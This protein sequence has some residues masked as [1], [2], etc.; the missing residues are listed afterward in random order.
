MKR[1]F[2]I[3]LAI[4]I[5]A[6]VFPVY[7]YSPA[8]V[9]ASELVPTNMSLIISDSF[10]VDGVNRITGSELN[11]T[12]TEVG[13]KTWEASSAF[14][15]AGSGNE[16]YVTSAYS[17]TRTAFVPYVPAASLASIEMDMKPFGMGGW[18]A[19][20]FGK[21]ASAFWGGGQ[22]WMFLREDGYY[23]IWVNGTQNLLAAGSIPSFDP[24]VYT[25]LRLDYNADMQ[26]V[27]VWVNDDSIVNASNIG[28]I[29]GFTPDIQ[30]AGFMASE[31]TPNEAAFKNFQ[32]K[33]EAPPVENPLPLTISDSFTLD[34]VN[35]IA[36]EALSGT[37]TEVGDR[38]W[39]AN[40]EFIFAGSGSGG[41]VTSTS[42]GTKTAF[43]PYVPAGTMSS[44]EVD[45]KPFGMG[46]WSAVGFSKEASAF[47]GSGQIWMFLRED[48][49]YNIWVNGTQNLL[50]NGFIA[51]FDPD[52]YTHLRLE[53]DAVMQTV[54]VWVNEDSIVNASNIGAIQGF[55]PD[56][57]YAGFMVSAQTP[58]ETA[59]KNFQVKGPA[60]PIED[61]LPLT[62]SDSFAVD[63]VNRTAGSEL[64][65]TKTEVGERTWE[66]SYAFVFAGSGNEGYVT[67]AYS[68]TRT[69][70]VP[71]VPA[72]TVS[73]L[74][75]DIKPFGMEGWSAV[76][77]SKEP[78]AFWGG[79]QIW[80]FI[81]ED[82][83]YNIWVNG[84]QNLLAAGSLA[85]FDPD[86]Y[87]HLRL[88]YNAETK[89]VSVWVNEDPILNATNIGGIQGFT[90]DI[91]YAGFM[92]NAQTPNE[93]AFKNFQVKGQAD[94]VP[95]EYPDDIVKP[96]ESEF[97]L[98]VFEDA[99]P[100]GGSKKAFKTIISELYAL[101]FD[102]IML[103]NGGVNR[104]R[105]MFEVTDTY[106]LNVYLNA[107]YDIVPWMY[108]D[109]EPNNIE[110]ARTVA[111]SIINGLKDHPS[112]KAINLSD[113]PELNV[114]Q[115]HA[116]LTQAF[117]EQP[118]DLKI[119]TPLIGLDRVGP[120][121]AATDMDALLIDVYPNARANRVGNFNMNGYG[122]PIWDFVSY[123]RKVSEN[124]PEDKPLWVILQAF[125][126]PGMGSRFDNRIPTPAELRVQNWL[127]IGEGATGIFWFLYTSIPSGLFGIRDNPTS[128]N[129][130]KSLTER[131]TPLR[132]TLLE[133]KKDK[134]RFTASAT[135]NVAP[136][137]STLVSKDGQKT[138]VVAVNMDCGG[139]Q[140]ITLESAYFTGQL[141]NM[142]TGEL[143]EIG[144]TGIEFEPGDGQMFE[145]IPVQSNPEPSVEIMMP[146]DGAVLV[147]DA[148]PGD[149]HVVL[150][151]AAADVGGV[152]QVEFYANGT[153]VGVVSAEPYSFEWHN[154]K[155]GSYSITAVATDNQGASSTSLPI[156]VMV[157]GEDNLLAN[158]SFEETD[159]HEEAAAWV[160]ENAASVT[161]AVYHTGGHSMQISAAMNGVLLTQAVQ[162]QPDTEYE[163]S[164]WVKTNG[165]KGT[166][167]IF[168]YEQDVPVAITHE[169]EN[170]YGTTAWKRQSITFTTPSYAQSGK[171]NISANM[172]YNSGT[173]WIDNVSLVPTGKTEITEGLAV[174]LTFDEAAGMTAYDSSVH[175]RHGT[176]V[177]N[178]GDGM[179]QVPSFLAGKV[180]SHSLFMDGPDHYIKVDTNLKLD[181]GSGFTIGAWIKPE[182]TAKRQ[183]IYS[184]GN[185]LEMEFENHELKVKMKSSTSEW[186]DI[187]GGTIS[188]DTWYH[189]AVIYK[190]LEG[191]KLFINGIMVASDPA[192]EYVSGEDGDHYFGQSPGLPATSYWG[193]I[194]D[195]RIY[196]RAM[197][198]EELVRIIE[199]K[200]V[201]Q[202]D[203]EPAAPAI[204]QNQIVTGGLGSGTAEI[205]APAGGY[206]INPTFAADFNRYFDQ[207]FA[208]QPLPLAVVTPPGPV[209]AGNKSVAQSSSNMALSKQLYAGALTIANAYGEMTIGDASTIGTTVLYGGS[210]CQIGAT[211]KLVIYGDIVC[212]GPLTFNGY[213]DGLTIHGKVIAAGDI[214]FNSSVGT[215]TI[216]ET[217]SSQG[218]IAFKGSNIAA[219]VIKGDLIGKGI[220]FK[221]FNSLSVSGNVSSTADFM[222]S[223]GNYTSFLIGKSLYVTG[224]SQFSTLN[225]VSIQGTYYGKGNI[226]MQG[227]ISNDG[228]T[229]GNCMLSSGS[230][231]FNG[232]GGAVNIGS[233]LGALNEVNFQSNISGNVQLGGISA[234]QIHIYNNFAP[235]NI[236]I[237][238]NPPVIG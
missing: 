49:Y 113:E 198:A 152:E 137:I 77:F 85:S 206:T 58:N 105:S 189:T 213:I 150:E 142:E 61:P 33:E 80:M 192:F 129:E 95:P 123:L 14:V 232:I 124:K 196:D 234:G 69:A 2:S 237:S 29:A 236:F 163:L 172:P 88:E 9:K 146:A 1:Y 128:L 99:N 173:A 215:F 229:V 156:S 66:A 134:D 57:K 207:Q 10:T 165:I 174:H 126:Q 125:G 221:G 195:V 235:S 178:N 171:V 117:H 201:D 136:Y 82:G 203:E 46:G 140:T 176:M 41:Y 7:P 197:Q 127:S 190:E 63:G 21:E 226:L 135:G 204:F 170:V 6:A 47:W 72:G 158:P 130:I 111:Q 231:D 209:T 138:Y 32:V 115:K 39:E 141:K 193:L 18:A 122:Y 116:L 167:I 131:V 145:V 233:F 110:A 20:G 230:I 159:E 212:N 120:M 8:I 186:V 12:M 38:T 187:S 100:I 24:D 182:N 157:L 76:G 132:P 225:K 185:G 112:V 101:G 97:P 79:G 11:D 103:A 56:I 208:A 153:K 191:I 114:L 35:R 98:G 202:E 91:E 144:S 211:T 179:G 62:I 224:K 143:Y 48:G 54:S 27:S 106:G 37:V 43:V 50:A 151:A 96:V 119:T 210:S 93:A 118:T 177:A 5:I 183:T 17:G 92:V 59:F 84:T 89:T 45:I 175:Q 40:S 162:L 220:S 194:D 34:G 205:S 228:F 64:N 19:V 75:V 87:T 81:R 22:I 109:N 65:D 107:A 166:G 139:P 70:F 71:Y 90:P 94:P 23:N 42:S 222:P 52:E 155:A 223:S 188:S 60:V 53:H 169:T 31:Q 51:S 86:V 13:E 214:T 147:K 219:G 4:L 44:I 26:T 168:N 78:S 164:G 184:D 121:F 104:D 199:N 68:G 16:G 133:A 148:S 55:T 108:N 74:E 3:F 30:F 200:G 36:G 67:S 154:V 238:F 102:S 218:S 180:G 161:T 227:Q 25:H 181:E 217:L 15:F 216:D 160:N 28:G 149:L 73:S 83:Y